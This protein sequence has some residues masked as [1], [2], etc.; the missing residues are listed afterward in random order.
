MTS[1]RPH[2][3]SLPIRLLCQR[4]YI[5][6]N[7]KLY[8]IWRRWHA[9]WCLCSDVFRSV[10]ITHLST[11]TSLTASD[12]TS[13]LDSSEQMA[14]YEVG[15]IW[16]YYRASAYEARDQYSY[17]NSVCLYVR[18][19]LCLKH[20]GVVSKRTDVYVCEV[21]FKYAIFKNFRDHSEDYPLTL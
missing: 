15:Y 7:A 4:Q 1:L 18:R 8:V 9:T 11:M 3:A 17:N 2:L 6:Q 20:F 12:R 13:L 10:C 21:I 14:A 16:F 5:V 19:S